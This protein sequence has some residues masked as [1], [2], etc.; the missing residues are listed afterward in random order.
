MEIR[1][2]KSPGLIDQKFPGDSTRLSEF[3]CD[4]PSQ[5]QG[6]LGVGVDMQGN[7]QHLQEIAVSC[8]NTP[9]LNKEWWGR[10]MDRGRDTSCSGRG[11]VAQ[12][13]WQGRD[14][15]GNG[16]IDKVAGQR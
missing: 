5:K 13:R 11:M 2:T 4:I 9:P 16:G 10:N 3:A 15:W 12:L 14:E 1:T 6:H 7:H 8:L